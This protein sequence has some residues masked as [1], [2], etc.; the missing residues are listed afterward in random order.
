[1]SANKTVADKKTATVVA[2]DPDDM[3]GRLKNIGGW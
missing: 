3:K 2:D 1:M